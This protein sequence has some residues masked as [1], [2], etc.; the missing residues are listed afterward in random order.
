M[1]LVLNF[2]ICFGLIMLMFL[3]MVVFL[4]WFLNLRYWV[5]LVFDIFYLVWLF[6]VI[7]VLRLDVNSVVFE[8]F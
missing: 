2:S 1:F 5:S 4:K 8:C 3:S 6:V 7:I